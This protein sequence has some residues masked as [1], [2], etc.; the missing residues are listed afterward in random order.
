MLASLKRQVRLFMLSPT[1]RAVRAENLTM[2][3]LA[4]LNRLEATAR[5]VLRAGVPGDV[6]EFGMAL[7]GSGII[8]ARQARDAGR[9]FHGFDVFGMIPP[10]DS[11]KD[12][13]HSKARYAEIASGKSAG[14]NGETY[15]GYLDDL[16]GRVAA[17]F[18][19]HGLPVGQGVSL[20][21]GLFEETLPVSLP[22]RI[23]LA[24]IDC[25]WYAPT[26]YCLEMV[27]PRMAAGAAIIVDDYHNYGGSRTAT[28][29]FLAARQDFAV[30]DG[31]NLVLRK[32]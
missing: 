8:L 10:P 31:D 24:H 17:A 15:Y 27:A 29:E 14:I 12:D 6:A 32:R 9:E 2:L 30:E 19:R 13:A 25:D 26:L 28:D 23:A 11:D 5:G 3:G 20:H 7:G 21:Q 16:R 1:A 4:K 18:G 22:E